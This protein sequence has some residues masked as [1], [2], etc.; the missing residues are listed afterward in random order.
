ML[1]KIRIIMSLALA[2]IVMACNNGPKV[3]TTSTSDESNTK[4]SGIFSEGAES[5]APETH[6]SKQAVAFG[7]DLHKVLVSEVL[8]TS[9]YIFLNVNE[10]GKQFWITTRKKEVTVGETYFYK[11]GL[12]KT[13]FESKE[14]NRV[15]DT[16]Y[17]VTNL[18]A[19]RHGNNSSIINTSKDITKQDIPVKQEIE[20]HT[21]KI[22]QHSGSIKISELVEDPK[23]YE[24]KTVQITGVCTKINAGIMDRNWIHLQDGSNNDFDLVV[25]SDAFVPEGSTITIKALVTLNKDF[26]AGYTYDL[27]LENGILI[28]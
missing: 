17:L 16:V 10:G 26:G 15:F 3:I 9:K 4:T 21:E 6:Q 18:V 28:K 19:E 7:D 8:P 22:V 14:Y 2:F 13:N 20:T 1:L 5:S 12:L 27:I 23:K 24:G 11:T 25:T